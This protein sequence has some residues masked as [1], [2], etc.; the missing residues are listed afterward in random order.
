M[1]G[2]QI[3]SQNAEQVYERHLQTGEPIDAIVAELGLSQISDSTALAE[4]VERV[5]AANPAAVADFRAGKL[6]AVKFLTGQAM[7]ETRGQAN[8]AGPPAAAR[9]ASVTLNVVLWVAGFALLAIG[10]WRSRAPFARMTELDRLAEN[11]RRYESWRGGRASGGPT[12][13]TGADV[14]RQL[15]RRQVFL[16]SVVGL[17]GVVLIVAGFAIR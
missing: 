13:T 17:I 16:W 12:E 9:G 1:S 7:K 5:V 4:V 3:S 8:P 6:Q 10:V 15:L 11:A 2:G 14:M